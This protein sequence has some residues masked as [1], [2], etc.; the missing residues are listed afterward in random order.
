MTTTQ[1]AYASV[2][3]TSGLSAAVGFAS[4]DSMQK[5]QIALLNVFIP[6]LAAICFHASY[7]MHKAQVTAIELMNATPVAEREGHI[8]RHWP[9]NAVER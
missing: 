8:E 2:Y 3:F 5:Y 6:I 4:Y 9:S 7:R 1:A